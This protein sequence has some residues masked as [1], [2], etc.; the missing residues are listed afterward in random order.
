MA[1]ENSYY[2]NL[3]R[4]VLQNESLERSMRLYNDLVPHTY[5][6][7][8]KGYSEIL[9]KINTPRGINYLPKVVE[10]IF[11]GDHAGTSRVGQYE[12]NLQILKILN[13]HPPQ[14]SEFQGLS[15]MWVD[16]ASKIFNHLEMNKD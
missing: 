1:Q 8:P 2:Q 10:D 9:R 12:L 5:A 3:L 11:L 14:S 6:P 4:N 7:S 15:D 13:A 16:I